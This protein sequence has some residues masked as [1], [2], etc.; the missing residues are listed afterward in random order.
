LLL[1]ALSV[2]I[3]AWAFLEASFWWMA[4]DISICIAYVQSP[5]HW[6]KFMIVALVGAFLGSA[7]TYAWAHSDPTGWEH[8]VSGMRFHSQQNIDRA[9]Q[10]LDDPGWAIVKGAW[11][12]IPYKLFFGAA[13]EQGRAFW[14]LA[15][16]GLAS[17]ALR[18][19]FSL[20]VTV[21]LRSVARPFSTR[22]PWAFSAVLMG[23]WIAMIVLFDV[24][25]N[26]RL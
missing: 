17:R 3:L 25:I 19:S 21:G 1:T 11:Q 12:G 10:S 26:A 24:V 15:A 14:P 13:G 9:A 5:A 18:F 6:R 16:W 4:P 22:R 7:V 2:A 23:I 20:A 8:A